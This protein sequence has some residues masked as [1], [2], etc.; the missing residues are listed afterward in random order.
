MHR[1]AVLIVTLGLASGAWA[2]PTETPSP[3]LTVTGQGEV[4][5]APDMATITLGVTTT[6]T[7][8]RAAMDETNAAAARIIAA[9]K[10][11]GVE[12][13]D[14]Q[15]RN[16]ELRPDWSDPDP[17]RDDAPRIDGFVASNTLSI[18]VR[19]MDALGS[20]LDTVLDQGANTFQGLGFG[21][22]DPQGHAD[23]ARREAVAEA[24]RKARLYADAAG[25]TLGPVLSLSEAGGGAPAPMFMEAARKAGDMAIES[26]EISITE[27]VTMVFAV[28][29]PGGN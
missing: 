6:A 20:V 17:G 14:I 29:G 21:L 26:G 8:A 27:S 16:L 19:R 25:L 5:A 10:A 4:F 24:M 22:Q 2:E 3:T 7:E 12:R 23:Q 28:S 9:L 15:T 1:L 13:R 11:A 18:R